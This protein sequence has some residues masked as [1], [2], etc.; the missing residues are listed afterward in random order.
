MCHHCATMAPG[1][2]YYVI[3]VICCHYAC[4]GYACMGVPVYVNVNRFCMCAYVHVCW[5]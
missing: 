1:H 5:F 4:E 3:Y 2:A